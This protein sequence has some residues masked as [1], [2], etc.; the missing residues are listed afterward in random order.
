MPCLR[1]AAALAVVL[2]LAAL[3]GEPPRVLRETTV[4]S[5]PA[6]ALAAPAG[7]TVET[8]TRDQIAES[9]NATDAEDALKYLPSLLV[10]KRYI[11]DYNHA[12]LS[13]RASGT[14]NSARSLVY[15]DGILLSNLLGNGAAFAPRWMMVAPE[16]IERVDVLYGPF[17]AA[18]PGN[19]VGAVVDFTTR[20]PGAFEAHGKLA[21][22]HQPF[23]LYGTDAGFSGHQAS[24]SVGSRHGDWACWLHAQRS[25]S[26]AQPQTFATRLVSQGTAGGAGTP[27]TGAWL[28]RN[29][30][31]QPWVILGAATQYRTVQ[32]QLKA[33]LAYQLAPALRASYTVGWWRNS[34]RGRPET[35]LRDA[36]GNPVYS[37]NVQIDGRAYTLQP[38][39][40]GLTNEALEHVMHGLSLKSHTRGEWD[41]EVAASTYRYQRDTLRAASVA[42]PAAQAGG[43]GR[44]VDMRGT[45]WTT[46]AGKGI[47]RP[48]GSAHVVEFGLQHDH[49]RLRSIDSRTSDW[50][51][52]AAGA[53]NN[54]FQGDSTLSSAYAQ[55]TWK[56]APRWTAMIGA[57]LEEWRAFNGATSNASTTVGHGERHE[58]YLSPKASLAWQCDKD[59]LLKAALGRAVR[60]PTV[61]ELYQGGITVAGALINN[62]PDLRPEQ[63]WSSELSAERDLGGRGLLRLTAFFER[64]RDALYSQTNVTATPNITSIQNVDRIRTRGLELAWQQADA[65]IEGLDLQSSLTFTDS[66]IT[67]NDKFP[68]SVGKWQ[69]RIPRWR[70]TAAATW[71]PDEHWSWTLAARYGGRQFSTLDN[72]DPNG[73]AYQAASRYFVTDL[74]LRYR[75]GPTLS[76]ALGIDN[77]NNARY[78]NFHPYPQRTFH[79]ELKA[80]L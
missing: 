55:D 18:Y 36:A 5:S 6:G 45:G 80:D 79:A 13:T 46:L 54:A 61:S 75:V 52:G 64:S 66:I 40:F 67:R 24:T 41:W 70:A 38:P 60:M 4:T 49:Y 76:V 62:D 69:P 43:A 22:S 58:T 17:S 33:K 71:R 53:R 57:R 78:W 15:A 77:L 68:A 16:E 29:R 8:V 44:I 25:D 11:G 35:Y 47:W 63:A 7:A 28:E 26:E 2:P 31:N 10:R 21:T 65:W 37:G 14:G 48:A 30:S 56:F 3:S 39:D 12:V 9:V 27:V 50:I 73:F 72:S 34:S 32:E 1:S 19:S 42:M 59:W 74:R 23:R 20:M 51:A